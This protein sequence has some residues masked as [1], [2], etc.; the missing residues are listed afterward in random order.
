MS[1]QSIYGEEAIYRFLNDLIALIKK[2]NNTLTT[3]IAELEDYGQ[4]K[5]LLRGWRGR[6]S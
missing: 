2:L 4:V 3:E 6:S 1:M 5:E